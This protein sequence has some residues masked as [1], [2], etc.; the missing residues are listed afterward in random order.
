[1]GRE[2]EGG[3]GLFPTK[4]MY[5]KDGEKRKMASWY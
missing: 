5:I 2:G 4:S 1:M 3:E